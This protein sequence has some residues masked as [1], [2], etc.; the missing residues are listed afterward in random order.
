MDARIS[1]NVGEI[2]LREGLITPEQLEKANRERVS[3]DKSLAR[4]LV[5]MGLISEKVKLGILQKKL[6]CE[7]LSLRNIK[8]EPLLTARVPR[9]LAFRYLAVPVRLDSDGL[10]VAMDDP[11]DVE[12][13]D[14]LAAI[15]QVKIKP[16]LA[17]SEDIGKILA[18][19]PQETSTGILLSGGVAPAGLRVIRELTF[20]FL[21]LAPLIALYFVLRYHTHFQTWLV[22]QDLS[23]FDISLYLLICWGTWSVLIYYFHDMVFSRLLSTKKPSDDEDDEE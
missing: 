10:L 9:G 6:G 2:L 1:G 15:A 17:T 4:V 16:V 20:W 8:I 18:Q 3:A 23:I 5:E 11:S 13:V 14:K 21:L 19:Y 12:A 7:I 22:K